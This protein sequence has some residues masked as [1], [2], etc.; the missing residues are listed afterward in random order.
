MQPEN[1]TYTLGL[2]RSARLNDAIYRELRDDFYDRFTHHHCPSDFI[3]GELEKH[4][5]KAAVHVIS[6][7][8]SPRFCY[9]KRGKTPALQGKEVVMMIGRLSNEKRQDVLID[10]VSRCRHRDSIQ[11]VLAGQGPKKAA[12]ERQGRRLPQPAD[13]RLFPR[14][15]P[16]RAALHDRPVRPRLGR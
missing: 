5:Y 1:I 7:G 6:N 11:L 13:L 12:L 2:G 10:A 14:G 3:A 16:T 8:I 4:G 15:A 9:R